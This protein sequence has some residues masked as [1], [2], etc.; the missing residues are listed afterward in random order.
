MSTID[1]LKERADA[2]NSTLI[3]RKGSLT[4]TE[5]SNITNQQAIMHT[6]VELLEMMP[7]KHKCGICGANTR[8]PH[9]CYV[10]RDRT[11]RIHDE[12]QEQTPPETPDHFKIRDGDTGPLPSYSRDKA[13]RKD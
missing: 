8:D 12:P 2:T 3:R 11:L 9:A 7:E 10:C 4:T 1:T 13:T 5:L 6:L